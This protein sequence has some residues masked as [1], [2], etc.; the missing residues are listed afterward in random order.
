MGLPPSLW[1]SGSIP[2][3]LIYL[4][5][6]VP[7]PGP[8]ARLQPPRALCLPQNLQTGHVLCF[9]L[10]KNRNVCVPEKPSANSCLGPRNS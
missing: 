9:P 8:V 3:A 6:A 7:G 1:I 4:F 5:S 10:A 2:S